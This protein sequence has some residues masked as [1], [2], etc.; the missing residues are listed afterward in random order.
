MFRMSLFAL[1]LYIATRL[2]LDGNV[3]D[4]SMAA[5]FRRAGLHV[6]V[7]E[8]VQPGPMKLETHE[9]AIQASLAKAVVVRS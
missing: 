3:V 1:V 9:G 6:P 8:L 2:A 7:A 4:E 5:L